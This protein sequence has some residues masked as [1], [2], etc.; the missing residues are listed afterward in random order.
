[1][2]P[3]IDA[4]AAMSGKVAENKTTS[5]V[6]LGL[7]ISIAGA[8]WWLH[9]LYSQIERRIETLEANTIVAI[10]KADEAK[11]DARDMTELW[12]MSVFGPLQPRSDTGRHR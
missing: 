12:R 2:K 10:Q 7:I 5:G 9:D 11:E 8:G 1:M 4:I 3:V 6:S